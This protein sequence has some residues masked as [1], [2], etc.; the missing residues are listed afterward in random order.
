VTAA[1]LA[2]YLAAFGGTA[3]PPEVSAAPPAAESAAPPAPAE[4]PAPPESP[5]A[6]PAMTVAALEPPP[7]PAAENPAPPADGTAAPPAAESAPAPQSPAPAGG[8]K[9]D[10]AGRFPTAPE[11]TKP[12][13]P[14]ALDGVSA[15][16]TAAKLLLVDVREVIRSPEHWHA[17]EWALFT[18]EVAAI[19]GV[20]AVDESLQ[21]DIRRRK[22]TAADNL[23]KD[24]RTFGNYGSFEVLGGFYLAGLIVHDKRA[25]ETTLDGLFASG[26]AGGLIT[27]F[28]KLAIGRVRPN[29]SQSAYK[30]KPFSVHNVSFPSGEATQAF[31]VAAVI[32]TQYPNPWV[33]LISYTTAAITSLGRIRQNGHWASDTLAGALIG[34]HV[35]RRVVHINQRLR[36]RVAL[37][38]LIAPGARGVTMTA[39]F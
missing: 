5:A 32:S 19:V 9:R 33:E 3:P 25:Q 30:F 6:P 15:G 24:F 39:S 8:R 37:A 10:A 18:T 14:E 28:L 22:S 12:G 7:P 4:I 21:R 27:P 16:M 1:F 11:G 20:G 13:S 34:Y 17:R 2:I 23:A 26:I 38:P 36:A 31:A 35:G 29:A